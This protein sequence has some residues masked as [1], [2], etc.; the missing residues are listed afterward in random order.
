M[1]D[2]LAV[3][4]FERVDD[5]DGGAEGLLERQRTA[6]GRALEVLHHQVVR[7]DVVEDADVRMVQR[8][9]GARFLVKTRAVTAVERLDG[10]RPAQ[11]RV[12][13]LVDLAHATRA[14]RGH[15]FIRT[16][17]GTGSLMPAFRNR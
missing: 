5:V 10:H 6:D 3:R 12:D 7:T 1:Q 15:D 2:A 4:G 8:R 9:D 13:G 11:A 14:Q 17:T 16:E